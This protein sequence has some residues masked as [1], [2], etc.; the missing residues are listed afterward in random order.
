MPTYYP[1]DSTETSINPTISVPV[2]LSVSPGAYLYKISFVNTFSITLLMPPSTRPE[3]NFI[4][5]SSY[6]NMGDIDSCSI[7]ITQIQPNKFV[8]MSISQGVVQ[9]LSN[10]LFDLT[11]STP[12][13]Q[14]DYLQIIFDPSFG[15][16]GVGNTVTISGY[17][18]LALTKLGTN[19]IISSI[20]QQAVLNARLIFTIAGI[21]MPFT[22][23]VKYINVSLLTSDNYYRIIQSYA[24]SAVT[25]SISATITCLNV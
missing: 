23:S 22:A 2:T 4:T 13:F 10:L 3:S 17:G 7:S 9:V 24:Y 15:L 19:F 20:S 12:L 18:V 16:S 11:L 8:S 25:G 6:N 1:D 5:I 21:T 14:T